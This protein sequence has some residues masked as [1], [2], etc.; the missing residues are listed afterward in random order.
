[1][2][3][4]P[5]F[6]TE[7][8]ARTVSYAVDAE[9]L[10]RAVKQLKA[11][12]ADRRA[13]CQLIGESRLEASNVAGAFIAA[14]PADV[15]AVRLK[16]P[17]TDALAAMREINQALGFAPKA[18]SLADQRT[19]LL[20]FLECQAKRRR[21]TVLCIEHVDQQPLW[22]LGALNDLVV[23]DPG[24][25]S[26]FLVVLAGDSKLQAVLATPAL[27]QLRQHA[28]PPVRLAPFPLDDTKALLNRSVELKSIDKQPRAKSNGDRLVVRING[29]PIK[30]IRFPDGRF[31]IGR[32][33]AAD[34]CLPSSLISRNHAVITKG[35]GQVKVEDLD[36]TNGTY[37]GGRRITECHLN[38]GDIVDLGECEIQYAGAGG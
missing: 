25:P 26:D 4:Q 8:S 29:A 37:V 7:S 30:E 19:V 10:Q 13:V 31:V 32:S 2:S 15:V 1:M 5:H 12:F 24:R 6:Q 17:H 14:L 16:D 11:A 28:G 3:Y 27:D 18:P 38:P 34:I 36:S 23:A 20:M 9:R 21:R 22:L 33:A 35:A